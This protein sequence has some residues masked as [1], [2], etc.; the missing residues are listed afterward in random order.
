[1]SESDREEALSPCPFCGGDAEI[2]DEQVNAAQFVLCLDCGAEGPVSESSDRAAE[3]W[4]R[5]QSA[6]CPHLRSSAE[7]TQYCALAQSGADENKK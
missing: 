4:N 2:A 3:A 6:P 7:G 5:R 1:M